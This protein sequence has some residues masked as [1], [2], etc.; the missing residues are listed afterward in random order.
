MSDRPGFHRCGLDK[1]ARGGTSGIRNEC[2]NGEVAYILE[3]ECDT[4]LVEL[5]LMTEEELDL[6]ILE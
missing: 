5:V 4:A 2:L 1:D 3:H 6:V